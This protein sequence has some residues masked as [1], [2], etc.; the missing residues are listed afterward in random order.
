[1]SDNAPVTNA[2]NEIVI[3]RLVDAPPELVWEAMTNPEHVVHWWGP[4]GFTT[5]I[6]EMDVR[7]GGVWK[8]VMHGPDG[9]NYPNQSR[10]M[11]VVKPSRLVYS[12]AG[13][14]EGGAG[15]EFIST[16]TFEE[17]EG[18]T[19]VTI[20]HVFPTVAARERVV[21]EFGA[22]E[23]GKQCLA[24][25]AGQLAKTP[26]VVERI[27][28]A[29]RELVWKA[30]T[31]PDEMKQWYFTNIETFKAEPG[32]ETRVNV[33]HGGEDFPH[34]WKVTEV[35]QGEKLTYRWKYA[36]SPGE[37]FV[38]FALSDEGAKTKLVLTHRGLETFDP[39]NHP[40]YAR[41][42][43]LG[44]WT[45]LV[46]DCLREYVEEIAPNAARL[47]TISRDFDAPRELVWKAW[48]NPRLLA[49]WWGPRD[50]TNPVCELDL[51][52]GGSYRIVMRAPDGSEY[53]LSG[54]FR[55]IKPP[56]RL[57]MTMDC[58]GHP[59][60]WHDTVCPGRG[61]DPNPVGEMVTTVT[62]DLHDDK[63][64]LT[65]RTLFR[66]AAIRDGMLKVGMTEGWSLSL[67]RLQACL[68]TERVKP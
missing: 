57:V 53:P 40:K 7:P 44:G 59:D 49:Q 23:G 28:N 4:Q 16:W 17:D 26:I 41:G 31:N 55:E 68:A 2:D 19:K 30:I 56:E 8:H 6:K 18:K 1:M 24:R 12:N 65:V 14:R 45:Y 36:G 42:N 63:T 66:T 51:R 21:K 46:G 33:R 37:S 58:S 43:F 13:H 3:T 11:E 47:F 27:F 52:P 29:P 22:I 35:V 5:T 61:S 34:L 64:Q 38:T 32:F 50:F 60:A 54:T 15:V 62:L 67:D 39:E 20:R 25:L 10:F 9:A 48:T